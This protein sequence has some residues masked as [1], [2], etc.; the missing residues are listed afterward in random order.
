[1]SEEEI[2]NG[3]I[4]QMIKN[5]EEAME[6]PLTDTVE[7]KQWT[8]EINAL[9]EV[10]QENAKLKGKINKVITFSNNQMYTIKHQPTNDKD[11]DNYFIEKLQN[12]KSILE[13]GD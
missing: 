11:I 10:L 12:I 9:K 5:H 6:C 8:A 13:S 7:N 3:Y 4:L 1:M 2:N